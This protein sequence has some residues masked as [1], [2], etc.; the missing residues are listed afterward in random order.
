MRGELICLSKRRDPQKQ[1]MRSGFV[2]RLKKLVVSGGWH[3][4]PL[5]YGRH[6]R[7]LH[8]RTVNGFAYAI[9]ILVKARPRHI[10]KFPTLP[11]CYVHISFLK[12][13]QRAETECRFEGVLERLEVGNRRVDG[14]MLSKTSSGGPRRES[15]LGRG[16]DSV[17]MGIRCWKVSAIHGKCLLQSNDHQPRPSCLTLMY[18]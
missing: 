1:G 15:H 3:P 5:S 11:P 6:T 17:S 2:I 10:A 13:H 7:V 8:S 16:I 4:N 12:W 18:G 14:R 9:L